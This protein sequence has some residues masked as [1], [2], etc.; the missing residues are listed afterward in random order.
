MDEESSVLVGYRR[1]SLW[2]GRLRQRQ[3]GTP[4]SVEFDWDWVLQ[5]EERYGDVIGFHHTH[6]PGLAAPSARDV[7]T[8]C[9]WVSSFGKP[10]LCVIESEDVLTATLFRTDGAEGEPLSEVQRFPR[11]VLVGVDWRTEAA[12]IQPSDTGMREEA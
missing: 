6:P 9:A 7:R 5:R 8:M 10:L 12:G 4:T 2:Y 3:V 11:N 1:G